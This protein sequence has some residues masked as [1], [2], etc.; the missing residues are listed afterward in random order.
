[1]WHCLKCG[2]DVEDHFELCWNCQANKRGLRQFTQR[3]L[4]DEEDERVRAMVNK[5]HKPMNCLRCKTVLTYAGPRKF[6]QGPNFGVLGDLGE[7]LVAKES[8][9]MY[10][11]SECGHVEF[12]AFGE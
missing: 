5:K 7:L 3:E 4:A 12:F 8:V 1:M 11:C 9:E 10:I 6:H 2:E